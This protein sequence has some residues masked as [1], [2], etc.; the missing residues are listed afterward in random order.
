VC[1]SSRA[2][3]SRHTKLTIAIAIILAAVLAISS[4]EQIYILRDGTGATV[5]SK[6]NEAYLFLGSSSA[7]YHLSY[8]QYPVEAVREFF[9]APQFP[10]DYRV[11]TLVIRVAPSGVERFHVEYG[12]EPA[13]A[14]IFL[15][16]SKTVSMQCVRGGLSVSGLAL[17]LFQPLRRSNKDLGGSTIC[18][19]RTSTTTSSVV[20]L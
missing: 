5:F 15:H 6:R 17:N 12:K 3:L 18:S 11:S 19:G 2:Q 4:V 10:A 8:L 20:G 1:R 7:G 13:L 14:P 9:Y 16:P